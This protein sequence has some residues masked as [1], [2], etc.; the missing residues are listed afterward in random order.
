MKHLTIPALLLT[1][2]SLLAGSTAFAAPRAI[3]PPVPE[4]TRAEVREVLAKRRAEQIKRLRA[5]RDNGVFPRNRVS[6]DVINVFRDENG[7][8]C[9]VA[10]LIFLDGKLALVAKTAL[11]NNYVK[12]GQL[13]SGALYDWILASGFTIEEIAAIQLPDSPVT[14]DLHWADRENQKIIAHLDRVS[15]QLAAAND[16]SLDL[17]T[18]RLI[19]SGQAYTLVR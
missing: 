6:P 1:L 4:L 11:E 17:A 16:K 18:D 3:R 7:L 8:L 9:A 5:Y 10:N 15:T 19:A 13:E 2:F 12:M 14:I